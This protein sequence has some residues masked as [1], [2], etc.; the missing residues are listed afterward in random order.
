M[1]EIKGLVHELPQAN[2]VSDKLKKQDLIIEYADNPQYPEFLKFEAIND[3]C[4][5]LDSLSVGDE[6]EVYFN[7]KGRPWTDKTGK[8]S[9]FNS[10]QIWKVNKLSA[11]SAASRPTATATKPADISSA[12]EDDDLPF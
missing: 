12:A 3:K 6:V 11:G 10:L 7:Y 8:K 2:Q 1:A 9:Y 4:T 5:L